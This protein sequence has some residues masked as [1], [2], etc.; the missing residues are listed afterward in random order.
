MMN[1]KKIFTIALAIFGLASCQM[2]ENEPES[3]KTMG[4]LQ[5][6]VALP[7]THT[8]AVT[9]N[10]QVT[11]SGP[12]NYS[13][14][15]AAATLPQSLALPVGQYT[16]KAQTPGTLEKVMDHAFYQGSES[17]EI[18]S[19]ITTQTEVICKQLNIQV[20]MRYGKEFTDTY[21]SWMVTIEDGANS[22]LSFTEANPAPA[23][24]YW[25]VG[26]TVEKFTINIEAQPKAAGA[27]PVKGRMSITKSDA[28][29]DYEGDSD[30]YK[31]GDIIQI[32]LTQGE[33]DTPVDPVEPENTTVALGLSI[34]TDLTFAYTEETVS[35][36][37]IWE[38]PEPA[39]DVKGAPTIVF[40]APS[41]E[42]TAE[43]GPALSATIKAD[44]GLK[45]ILVKAVSDGGFQAAMEDLEDSG[46]HLVTGHEL[47]A[48]ELLPGVFSGLGIE[49]EMPQSGDK[50]YIFNIANFYK[51]MAIYGTGT[52]TFSIVVTD[53]DGQTAEG[54]VVVTIKE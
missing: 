42:A 20:Q 48:D 38:K 37:V 31:G 18:K 34:K 13:A 10:F 33:G 17:F 16:V 45:S 30:Y 46:L 21:K 5:L 27:N 12:N 1:M 4:Q 8:R 40:T 53:M 54:S 25:N 11:I 15:Y 26:E 44:A 43:N 3:E 19:G 35:I 6:N 22:V 36:P 52:T 50:E 51:F 28:S 41:V 47:V 2:L 23:P 32:N 29:E 14:Q 7:A 24:I 9:D 49:A 39:P